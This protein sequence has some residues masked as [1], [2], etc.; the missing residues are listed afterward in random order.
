M[1]SAGLVGLPVNERGYCLSG[2]GFFDLYGLIWFGGFD[3]GYFEF[4]QVYG[5]ASV[6]DAHSEKEEVTGF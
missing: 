2:F 4:E 5:F 1:P 3:V 6:V